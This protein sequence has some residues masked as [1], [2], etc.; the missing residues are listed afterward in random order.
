MKGFNIV[1][2]QWG[3]P[4]TAQAG[5]GIRARPCHSLRATG[6]TLNF[7]CRHSACD[8]ICVFRK[9]TLAEGGE[10]IEGGG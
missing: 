4:V 7:I 2:E 3:R 8:Q 5:G 10:R 9:I 1:G 6:K